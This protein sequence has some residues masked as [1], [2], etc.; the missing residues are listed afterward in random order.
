MTTE[1]L[2]EIGL[3]ITI[4]LI[5]AVLYFSMRTKD[6]KNR[7]PDSILNEV[8]VLMAYGKHKDA[9]ELLRMATAEFPG[10]SKLSEKLSE[11]E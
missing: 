6:V 11:L 1:Y 2:S 4:A 9:A 5:I 8:E 10:K 7:T 3:L